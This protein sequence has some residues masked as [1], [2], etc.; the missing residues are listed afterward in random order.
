MTADHSDN[1]LP[2]TVEGLRQECLKLQNKIKDVEWAADKTNEG[3][4]VL[5]KELAK[6]NE[7]LQK[8]DQLKSDFVATVSHEL[9]TPLTIIREGVSLI[10]DGILGSVTDD[11][12]EILTDV[13]QNI[14]RLANI[15]ND[16]LDIS[17]LEA[18]NIKLNKLDIEVK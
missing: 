5:Y 1:R 4:R 6:K 16:L 17:K 15:I 8:L 12:N 2:D 14:D 13:I 10:Q 18:G 9:R 11:Q 3:V 7:E